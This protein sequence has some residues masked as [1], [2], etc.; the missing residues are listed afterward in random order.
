VDFRDERL[1]V[2]LKRFDQNVIEGIFMLAVCHTVV[3]EKKEN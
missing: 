1:F 3:T 2:R